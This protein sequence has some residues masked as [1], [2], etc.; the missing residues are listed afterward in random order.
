MVTLQSL[1]GL[2]KTGQTVGDFTKTKFQSLMSW[3]RC[4]VRRRV[5]RC[6]FFQ[7]ILVGIH[8]ASG[9]EKLFD[10]AHQV[11][12]FWLLRVSDIW[13]LHQT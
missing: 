5:W 7:K 9:V 4:R 11:D 3:L 10:F 2:F 1:S 12:C 13:R 6:L 8:D